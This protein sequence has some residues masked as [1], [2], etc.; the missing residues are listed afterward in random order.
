MKRKD[1]MAG[2]RRLRLLRRRWEHALGLKH[3]FIDYLYVE[4]D[5]KTDGEPTPD[6]LATCT[7]D[8]RYKKATISY[9]MAKVA[10]ATDAWLEQTFVHE[11]M[12]MFV[13]EL[14][15]GVRTDFDQ[16]P[17]EER[18]CTQLGWAFLWTREEALKE[19]KRT[20]LAGSKAARDATRTKRAALAAAA[21][22]LP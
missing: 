21:A 4:S 12:H 8:W 2:R 1:F 22:T 6:T 11:H 5:F 13:Q 14:R 18:V 9:N 20:R 17:H 16:L 7:A 19:G 15:E 3:W 10:E